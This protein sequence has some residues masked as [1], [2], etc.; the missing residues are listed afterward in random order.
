MIDFY[1]FPSIGLVSCKI[2]SK[3]FYKVCHCCEWHFFLYCWKYRGKPIDFLCVLCVYVYMY[4]IQSP[5][6]ILLLILQGFFFF[7]VT[8]AFWKHNYITCKL[9]SYCSLSSFLL[10]LSSSLPPSS[11]SSFLYFPNSAFWLPTGKINIGEAG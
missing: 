7:F 3:I 5:Y 11:L 10:S 8:W 9:R 1:S 2:L 4:N 6:R